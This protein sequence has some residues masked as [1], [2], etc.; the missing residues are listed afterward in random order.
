MHEPHRTSSKCDAAA[1]MGWQPDVD[2][3]PVAAIR[4]EAAN[5]RGA[6]RHF[7]NSSRPVE[8]STLNTGGANAGDTLRV[9]S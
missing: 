1:I 5:R 2:G 8:K 3:S 7:R 9:E 4:T 6:M